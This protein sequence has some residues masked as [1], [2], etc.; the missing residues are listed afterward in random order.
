MTRPTLL[1]DIFCQVV[2][3]YGDIGV[4]WRLSADLAER[5]HQVRLW[6]DD[7]SALQWMAP[8]GCPGVTVLPWPS[9]HLPEQVG[10]VLLETF[11]CEIPALFLRA[12]ADK[13][14]SL[15]RV[16][17]WINLE[18]LSAEPYVRRSHGL[19]SP[20]LSGPGQGLAK[21]FFYPGFTAGTGGLLRETQLLQRQANFCP[22]TWLQQ[23]GL[24]RGQDEQLISL[25]CYEP[26]ALEKL[27][28]L[29]ARP[30]QASQLMV[31]AG[32]ATQAVNAVLKQKKQ[33][34]T[35]WNHTQS[36]TINF[37]PYL[38]QDDFDHLLWSCDLNF[39]RGEDSLV[40][41]LWA[42][43]P[44]VW[45]IYPQPDAAHH[46]KLDAFLDQLQAPASLRQFHRS[47]NEVNSLP[48]GELDLSA[49]GKALSQCRTNLLAH[50]DLSSQLLAFVLA[51]QSPWAA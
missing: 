5:G 2:D 11:G 12:V 19:P 4:C 16:I 42:G 17:P 37:L 40:R 43:K 18:Y 44:L 50:T 36:L 29:L 3:N 31:T 10:D 1:W 14:S 26:K 22:K 25:F 32:R 47:W 13:S 49:W 27:L 9:E 23:Q 8:L 39:V 46:A 6:L 24:T 34:Q 48:L 7:A 41:A 35:Q 33:V 45:Q 38:S 20:V 51:L 30:G 21:H 15:G 28:D